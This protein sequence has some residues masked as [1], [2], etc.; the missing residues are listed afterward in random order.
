MGL[1]YRKGFCAVKKEDMFEVIGEARDEFVADASKETNRRKT[2]LWLKFAAA[3]ACLAIVGV[4]AARLFA[5]PPQDFSQLPMLSVAEVTNGSYGF[6]GYM[7]FDASE[8]VSGNPW[9]EGKKL[10]TLPVFE[11]AVSFDRAGMPHGGDFDKMRLFL[12]DVAARLGLDTENVTITDDVPD[13]KT[14]QMIKEKFEMVGDTVPEGYFDPTELILEQNGVKITVDAQMVATIHFDPQIDLPDDVTFNYY[15]S[16]YEQM[17]RAADYFEK[18]YAGFIDM[19]KPR[20]NISGGD[21]NIYREQSYD[22]SFY[23]SSGSYEQQII[24]FNFNRVVFYGN[25]EGRLWLARVYQPDLSKKVGDYPIITA[26]AAQEL[27][28]AGQYITT[29]YAENP[30]TSETTKKVE[31]VYRWG[32]GSAYYMPYYRFYVELPEME[33]EGGFKNYGAY[34]VPA[35]KSEFISDMP[36]WDG[37]FN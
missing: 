37:S 36:Q 29:V 16:S 26:D 12:L 8:L 34:Y 11:P 22:I 14:Q 6:E 35:V 13:E 25:E 32:E 27:L 31:L 4:G 9:Q 30:P 33:E 18:E 2:P 15:N 10:E 28:L 19:K 1:S 7:A 17:K 20:Q 24:N 5:A 3:A 21:Y 23:E